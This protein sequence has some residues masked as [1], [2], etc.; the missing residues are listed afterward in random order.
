MTLVPPFGVCIECGGFTF[1]ASRTNG[2]CS[3]WPGGKRCKG[4]YGSAIDKDD[5]GDVRPMQWLWSAF[6]RNLPCVPRQRLALFPKVTAI[7][8]MATLSK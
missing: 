6:W 5:W 1:D 3:R 7:T 4:V 2:N 8:L